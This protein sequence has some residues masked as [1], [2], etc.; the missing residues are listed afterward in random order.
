MLATDDL[1]SGWHFETVSR[2]V[3]RYATVHSRLGR[4]RTMC[5]LS[6]GVKNYRFPFQACCSV[7]VTVRSSASVLTHHSMVAPDAS[8]IYGCRCLA[9]FLGNRHRHGVYLLPI[10]ARSRCTSGTSCFLGG[11]TQAPLR[12]TYLLPLISRLPKHTPTY[13]SPSPSYRTDQRR[14]AQAGVYVSIK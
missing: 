4:P 9:R 6:T 2:T 11:R 1:E 7:I 5:Y 3:L 14:I 13:G 10:L 12:H 8:R